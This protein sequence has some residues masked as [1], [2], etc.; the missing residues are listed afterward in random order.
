MTDA[1][2]R[3]MLPRID[4]RFEHGGGPGSNRARKKHG[5]EI[6]HVNRQAL[7]V[8]P[9][10]AVS[11]RTM[12]WD[13]LRVEIVRSLAH[14][15]VEFRFRAS[16][17][18]L[19]VYEESVRDEGETLLGGPAASSSRILSRK[20]TFV[21]AGHEFRD[22]QRSRAR[23]R[24]I[25]FYF[26]PAKMPINPGFQS[27]APPLAPRLFFENAILWETAV[28]LGTAMEDGSESERYCEALG[29]VI[30]HELVRIF[31]NLQHHCVLTRGGLAV[32][33]QRMVAAYV[34]QHL[35]EPIPLTS[36]AKLVNL[37]SYHFCR[38]FKQ[39]FGVSPG[40]YHMTRRIERAKALLG[41]P[42]RSVTQVALAVGY[43]ETSSFSVAFRKV[44]GTTPTKYRRAF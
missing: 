38:V 15:K 21:P 36:L 14:D 44:T 35:T 11:R 29:I 20:L 34:E 1:V 24:I 8:I 4:G 41:D 13:G 26:D 28:K 23:N 12:A 30:A 6:V 39:S 27:A 25:C 10:R 3:A 37:S 5:F 2:Q 32:W 31:G 7:Q 22:W 33:R 19:L 18:L 40:R 9:A 16:C 17:H 42:T 43:K